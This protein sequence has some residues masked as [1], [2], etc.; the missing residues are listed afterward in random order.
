MPSRRFRF[1]NPPVETSSSLGR[2]GTA[3]DILTQPEPL[4]FLGGGSTDVDVAMTRFAAS[5]TGRKYIGH[6]CLGEAPAT[7]S[8]L[9]ELAD[10]A[11]VE[12]FRID[13]RD[14]ANHE[15][16]NTVLAASEALFVA[17]GDQWNY[18]LFV[19]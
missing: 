7:M 1:R 8:Y 17:G 13:S 5:C 12:T 6:P 9:L 4:I 10:A 11:S 2:S 18:T 19:G 16:D 3:D 15:P 14:R